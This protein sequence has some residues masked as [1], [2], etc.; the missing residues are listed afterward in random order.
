MRR[1]KLYVC[2][3]CGRAIEDYE[4]MVKIRPRGRNGKSNTYHETCIEDE[5][6]NGR[7]IQTIHT[8]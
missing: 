6:L 8:L 1:L 7:K 2:A 3:L 4:E 5:R